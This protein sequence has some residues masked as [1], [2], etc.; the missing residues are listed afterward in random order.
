MVFLL[1]SKATTDHRSTESTLLVGFA[2][3]VELQ[4]PAISVCGNDRLALPLRL[5]DC[6]NIETTTGHDGAERVFKHAWLSSGDE[7]RLTAYLGKDFAGLLF[8]DTEL[9]GNVS[10]DRPL[11]P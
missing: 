9:G 8:A 3:A 6:I 10:A 1:A 4:R 11:N 2:D 7:A 5:R